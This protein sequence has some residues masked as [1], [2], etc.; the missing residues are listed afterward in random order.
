MR[1]VKR[2]IVIAILVLVL[3]FGLLFTL[4]NSAQVSLD[5]LVVQLEQQRLAIW[6]VLAFIVGGLIGLLV[7]SLTIVRLKGREA[8]LRR[9]LAHRDQELSKLRTAPLKS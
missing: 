4:Q 7:S 6:L 5:L 8:A 9:K 1:F 2:I 3:L